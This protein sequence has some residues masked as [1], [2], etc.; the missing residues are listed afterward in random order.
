MHENEHTTV[1]VQVSVRVRVPLLL[2]MY[3]FWWESPTQTYYT[4]YE[5]HTSAVSAHDE[6]FVLF[7]TG[8]YVT[9]RVWLISINNCIIGLGQVA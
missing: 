4:S 7:H 5:Y 8:G 6:M 9:A 2:Y 3:V 1:A